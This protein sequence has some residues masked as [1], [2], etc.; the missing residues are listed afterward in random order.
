[1][2]DLYKNR[3][4]SLNTEEFNIKCK[5]R[6]KKAKFDAKNRKKNQQVARRKK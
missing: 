6:R 3:D 5:K 2:T 1:M 4:K